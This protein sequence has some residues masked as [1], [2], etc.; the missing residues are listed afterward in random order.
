MNVVD[1]IENEDHFYIITEVTKGGELSE[2]LA[3]V[4]YLTEL[5]AGKVIYQVMMALHYMHSQNIIHRD[6]KL[7]NL[8]LLSRDPANF[9]IKVCDLGF[10]QKFGDDELT[11]VM[12]TP[13]YMAP[14]LVR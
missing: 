5:Q 14:E 10:A 12:G 8:H 1:L 7:A 4:R 13:L 11:L 3:Q 2:R 6:M 9:D